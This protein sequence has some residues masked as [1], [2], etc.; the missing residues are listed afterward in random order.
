MLLFFQRMPKWTLSQQHSAHQKPQLSH[1]FQ[2]CHGHQH[3]TPV[4]INKQLKQPEDWHQILEFMI[5]QLNQMPMNSGHL[6]MLLNP[7][8]DGDLSLPRS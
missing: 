4:S 6:L 5:L 2:T 1:L 8:V 7:L 3:L